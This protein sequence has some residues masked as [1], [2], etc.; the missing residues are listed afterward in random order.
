MRT[1]RSG[2]QRVA[3]LPR[4]LAFLLSR[5]YIRSV[6]DSTRDEVGETGEFR[7][8]D[9]TRAARSMSVRRLPASDVAAAVAAAAAAGLAFS[10]SSYYGH[11]VVVVVVFLSR[12]FPLL[13]SFSF[14]P[15]RRRYP[16]TGVSSF[17]HGHANFPP[18]IK[19]LLYSCVR[20]AKIVAN[21][22]AGRNRNVCLLRKEKYVNFMCGERERER[23]LILNNGKWSIRYMSVVCFVCQLVAKISFC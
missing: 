20:Y 16:L 10:R 13:R 7:G 1:D 8:V 11:L 12:A 21:V 17:S 9:G 5:R 14:H 15:H 22:T 6:R 18:R 4:G 23:K 2:L 3:P 19:K